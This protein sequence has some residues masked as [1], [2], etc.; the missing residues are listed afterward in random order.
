M[1]NHQKLYDLVYL[2]RRALA[3]CH[4]ARAEELIKQ[5]FRESVKAKNTEIIKLSSNA[6][7]ECRRFHFLDVL[8][9][10]NRI[11]PI[12]AKRKELS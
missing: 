12:Q 6:L 10:L 2:A 3:S 4:Y 11:D 9:E 5:L 8:H 1:T 7:L